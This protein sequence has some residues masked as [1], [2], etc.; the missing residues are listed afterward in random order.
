MKALYQAKIYHRRSSPRVNEFTYSGFYIRFDLAK[1]ED[2]AGALFGVNRFNLFSFYDR[3]HGYRDE[4]SL[5][6]WIEDQLAEAGIQ[7]CDHFE[8][9]TF[10]RVLGYVF[11]PVSFWYCYRGNELE[12]VLCEVNNTFG[13]SHNYLIK[14]FAGELPKEFHVSPFFDVSGHYQ[15]N[16]KQSNL[17]IINYFENKELLLTTSIKG[18]EILWSTKN[19]LKLFVRY[20]FFTM[21]VVLLIH[22]QALKLWLKRATFYSLP[23]KL[24]KDLT[25][26]YRHEKSWTRH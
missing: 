25:Y 26:D 10:P 5:K 11:N 8:L 22:F 21:S 7:G 14:G 18:E 17:V 24:E 16:F 3:D 4:R 9:Q 19:F 2:L 15:F 23:K 20:P 13:E 1:V 12:A 6:S